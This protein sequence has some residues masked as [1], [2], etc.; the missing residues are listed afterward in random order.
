[1]E[2]LLLCRRFFL[3]PAKD[4]S[5]HRRYEALR[6]VFVDGESPKHVAEH[7]G[8]RYDTVR[9]MISEFRAHLRES[10]PPPFLSSRH[11]GGPRGYRRSQN[12]PAR[13]RRRW[14]IA[15]RCSWKPDAGSARESPGCF[16]SCL[17]WP[18][19]DLTGWFTRPPIPARP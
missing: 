8:Y 15:V 14:R 17:F 7:F 5:L 6:A 4:D 18:D 13:T 19:Y 9:A 10:H 1:M 3:E 16:F 12:R 2:D 11:A